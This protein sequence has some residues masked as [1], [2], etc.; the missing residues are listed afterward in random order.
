[1]LRHRTR[2]IL[3]RTTLTHPATQYVEL[4]VQETG[5]ASVFLRWFDGTSSAT[6]TIETTDLPKE[7]AAFDSTVATEWAPEAS[8]VIAGP[9]GSAAGAETVHLGNNGATRMR[10]KIE[11]VATTDVE[12]WGHWK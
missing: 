12:V 9:S 8:V 3:D 10:L 6:V 5:L 4:N 1:M 2:K 7:E 11:T